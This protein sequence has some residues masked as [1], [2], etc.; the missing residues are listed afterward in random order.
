MEFQIIPNKFSHFQTFLRQDLLAIDQLPNDSTHKIFTRL[1]NNLAKLNFIFLRLVNQK[2]KIADQQTFSMSSFSYS[3][4]SAS[5]AG[6]NSWNNFPASR[7]S[8]PRESKNSTGPIEGFIYHPEDYDTIGSPLGEGAF[9]KTFLVRNK[10]SGATYVVKMMRKEYQVQ[11]PNTGQI[12]MEGTSRESFER[13][14]KI[15][16]VVSPVCKDGILCIVGEGSA[17]DNDNPDFPFYVLVTEFLNHYTTLDKFIAKTTEVNRWAKG[18][19]ILIH[20]VNALENMHAAKVAH[21]DIKPTNLMILMSPNSELSDVNPT[22]I[23]DFGLSCWEHECED[24]NTMGGTPE[25]QPPEM[26]FWSKE[27]FGRYD[28]VPIT[29]DSFR[30]GDQYSLGVTMIEFLLGEQ[31]FVPLTIAKMDGLE[32]LR[33]LPTEYV[34]KYPHL[35]DA[36]HQLLLPFNERKMPTVDFSTAPTPA[37]STKPVPLGPAPVPAMATFELAYAQPQQ[38]TPAQL[39]GLNAQGFGRLNQIDGGNVRRPPSPIPVLTP[40]PVYG[41]FPENP[42][43]AYNTPLQQRLKRLRQLQQFQLGRF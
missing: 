7:S 38:F 19:K 3:P 9:G 4:S 10:R 34:V 2:Q 26:G 6:P 22:V 27:K 16:E 43:N 5:I 32:M 30:I 31:K 17:I 1:M 39:A 28:R 23:I 11:D 35:V 20:L 14:K 8:E 40:I 37:V 29:F 33:Q 24:P 18:T 41:N 36:I 42:F 25:Y 21:R 13:E 15:L 12:R